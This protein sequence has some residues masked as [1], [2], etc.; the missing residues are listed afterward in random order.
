MRS[1]LSRIYSDIEYHIVSLCSIVRVYSCQLHNSVRMVE[2]VSEVGLGELYSSYESD[3]TQAVAHQLIEVE[4]LYL[5]SYQPMTGSSLNDSLRRIFDLRVSLSE[6]SGK[7]RYLEKEGLVKS[8]V[9]FGNGVGNKDHTSIESGYSIT[10]LGSKA[11]ATYI[12]SLST[13]A[14]TM[15]LGLNQKLVRG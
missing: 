4:I 13:V 6:L 14:L 11:L 2:D 9:S 12:E 1:R 5:L 7:L 10:P 15:Q 8:V 3:V